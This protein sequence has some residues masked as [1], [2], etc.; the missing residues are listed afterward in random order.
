MNAGGQR[1]IRYS[2]DEDGETTGIVVT[3]AVPGQEMF[4][5]DGKQLDAPTFIGMEFIGA[6]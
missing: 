5:I 2:Y 3:Q 1:T 4:G 6:L